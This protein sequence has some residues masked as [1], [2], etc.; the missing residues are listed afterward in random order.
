MKTYLLVKVSAEGG[1]PS[2]PFTRVFTDKELVRA[3]LK[4]LLEIDPA[5]DFR[6]INDMG[7]DIGEGV[8]QSF[9]YTD[10]ADD[11]PDRWMNEQDR[12]EKLDGTTSEEMFFYKEM[13]V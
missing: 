3:C 12:N 13:E 2:L 4:G 6:S 10:R 9:F 8:D 11:E 7:A 5:K 1:T